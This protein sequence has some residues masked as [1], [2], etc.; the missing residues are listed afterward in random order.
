[1]RKYYLKMVKAGRLFS[2]VRYTRPLPRD[3]GRTRAEKSKHTRAAQSFI[4][5]KNT[6]EQ[7]ERLLWANFESP[8]ACFLTFTYDN[9]HLPANKKAVNNAITNFL[10]C[11]RED[12]KRHDKEFQYIYTTEG[13]PLST[14]PSA[15]DVCGNLW[16]TRPWDCQEKW[17]S[18]TDKDSATTL[19]ETRSHHHAVMLLS[20]KDYELVR[21]NWPYGHVYIEKIKTNIPSS[22]ERI[23]YYMTK[24]SRGGKKGNGKRAYNCS[25]HLIKPTIEGKWVEEFEDIRPPKGATVIWDNKDENQYSS[26]HRCKFIMPRKKQPPKEYKSRHRYTKASGRKSNSQPVRR[27]N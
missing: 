13:E 9:K 26:C 24:E 11:I 1:M 16:E 5:A 7:L 21:E 22:F 23:A 14:A 3:T 17:E 2:A 27:N 12:R 19:N 20:P 10:A 4:N 25:L 6:A 8:N 15:A 18:V